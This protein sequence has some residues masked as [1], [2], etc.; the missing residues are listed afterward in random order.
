MK[1]KPLGYRRN[2]LSL[3]GTDFAPSFEP[4][5]RP[6]VLFSLSTLYCPCATFLLS[7]ALFYYFMDL[8]LC[9]NSPYFCVYFLSQRCGGDRFQRSFLTS[10]TSALPS[11]ANYKLS[12]NRTESSEIPSDEHRFTH[13]FTCQRATPRRTRLPVSSRSYT[14]LMN[15]CARKK[16]VPFHDISPV[17]DNWCIDRELRTP[18]ESDTNIARFQ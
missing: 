17:R 3:S 1:V 14:T 15:S 12:K 18:Y 16:S 5:S 10:L 4:T 9:L 8:K 7:C 2:H 6:H 13:L 11:Q